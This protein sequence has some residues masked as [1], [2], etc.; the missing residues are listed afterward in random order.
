M[1][2][3]SGALHASLI[4]FAFGALFSPEAYQFFPY[5]AVAYTSALLAIVKEGDLRA[6]RLPPERKVQRSDVLRTPAVPVHT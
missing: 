6:K 3:F 5:F 2:L 4:G 1:V